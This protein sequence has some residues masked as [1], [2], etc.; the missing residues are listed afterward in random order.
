VLEEAGVLADVRLTEVRLQLFPLEDD[1]LSLELDT[2][3]R[4]CAVDG[5]RT[6]LFYVARA[7]SRL[8]TVF[9][10][11]PT[12]RGIGPNA[13]HVRDLLQ[14]LRRE[15][16]ADVAASSS[17]ASPLV[18]GE[19]DLLVLVDRESD[20]ITPM[21]TQLTYEG[22]VDELFGIAHNHVDLDAELLGEAG[23]EAQAASGGT[24][25]LHL[26]EQDQSK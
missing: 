20:L 24:V 13:K 3:F 6:G 23:R 1:L 26:R 14:R 12:I 8:Q 5:D 11:V 25:R 15:A 2:V 22:L 18:G 10:P 19:I 4:E 21:C 17:G 16:A 9:G 7:L